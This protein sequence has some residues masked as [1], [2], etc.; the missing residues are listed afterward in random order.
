[1]AR[2]H[3]VTEGSTEKNFVDNVLKP[4][5]ALKGVYLDAHSVTTRKDRRKN[6]IYRGG[7]DNVEHLIRDLQLWLAESQYQ[8]DCFVTTMVDLYAFPYHQKPEWIADFESQPSGLQKAQFLEQK[9]S[10]HFDQYPRFIPYIQVH[11]F[12]ALLLT[13]IH[14]IHDAFKTLHSANKLQQ[15]KEHLEGLPPEDVNQGRQSAP[16]KRIIKFYPEYEDDKPTWGTII[17]LE[18]GIDKMR[19]VCPHFNEWVLTLEGLAD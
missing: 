2:V 11:E 8:N 19:Q 13:D 5:L 18:I 4:Y 15:L 17:A 14:T 12:E 16:S 7:L 9:L 10:E 3:V 6:K 1:M